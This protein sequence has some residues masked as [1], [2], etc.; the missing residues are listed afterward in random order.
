MSLQLCVASGA[1]YGRAAAWLSTALA[2]V[3]PPPM[4]VWV[5]APKPLPDAAAFYLVTSIAQVV[6]SFVMPLVWLARREW[7]ARVQFAR[8]HRDAAGMASL[9]RRARQWRLGPVEWGAL[10]AALWCCG[11]ASARAA[12]SRWGATDANL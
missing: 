3:L 4:A 12:A 11:L 5:I 9:H 8:S 7:R 6:C 10:A 1:R 2:M